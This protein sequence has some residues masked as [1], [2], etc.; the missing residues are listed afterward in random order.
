MVVYVE[1]LGLFEDNNHGP[2]AS[3]DV[4]PY[5]MQAGIPVN[6]HTLPGPYKAFGF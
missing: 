4:L 2:K 3:F 1:P 6:F 5:R